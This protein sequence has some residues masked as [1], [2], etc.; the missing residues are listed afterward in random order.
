MKNNKNKYR[1]ANCSDCCSITKKLSERSLIIILLLLSTRLGA[2]SQ[3]NIFSL[4]PWKFQ[5][6]SGGIAME[7]LYRNQKNHLSNN[8]DENIRYDDT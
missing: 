8:F 7:G 1:L 4:G 5:N 2:Y 6:F 3:D